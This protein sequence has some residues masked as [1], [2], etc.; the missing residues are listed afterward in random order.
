MHE[1]KVDHSIAMPLVS[2]LVAT[3]NGEHLLDELLEILLSSSYTNIEIVIVDDFSNDGT[4]KV[5]EKWKAIDS[6][7]R[8]FR[9]EKNIGIFPTYQRLYNL[10]FGKYVMWNDQDDLHDPSFI[11]KAVKILESDESLV[12]CHSLTEVSVEGLRVH[13][14]SIKSLVGAK[15]L[16]SRYWNLLRTFS[17]ITIYG[18]I[19]RDALIETQL[20]QERLGS[21]NLLL[22][23][24]ILAGSFQQIEEVLFYYEGKGV[25]GRPSTGDELARSVVRKSNQNVFLPSLRILIAQ[26]K[27]IWRTQRIGV[28]DKVLISIL[29]VLYILLGILIK[30][31]YRITLKLFPRIARRYLLEPLG[32][33][34]FSKK[35]IVQLVIR[36][37]HPEIYS[38]DFPLGK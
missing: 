38:R 27:G 17:D 10:S 37:E 8:Y 23:E 11:T 13:Q 24:L 30:L 15:G 6:R 3:Y 9:N 20:W 7:I 26:V 2:I 5:C 25:K 4:Q 36:D 12:L 22:F 35:D 32:K 33:I 29:S 28:L 21:C 16:K 34:V 18:L 14:T 19:K 1:S 31:I